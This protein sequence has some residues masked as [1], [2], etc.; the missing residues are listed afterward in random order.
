MSWNYIKFLHHPVATERYKM[1]V[2]N[3]IIFCYNN[4]LDINLGKVICAICWIL[5]T[6]SDCIVC[7]D[8]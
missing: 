1:R 3:T 6:C 4:T 8:K 7:L 2:R 5:C